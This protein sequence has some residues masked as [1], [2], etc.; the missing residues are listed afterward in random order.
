MLGIPLLERNIGFLVSWVLGF[1][2]SKCS[3]FLVSKFLGFKFIGSAA[4]TF[5]GFKVSKIYQNIISCFQEDIGLVSK[6]FEISLDIS[7][8]L[9]APIFSKICKRSDF[10]FVYL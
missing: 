7:S 6:I 2:V 8:G 5:R 4:S 10:H 9:S 3:G 1:L